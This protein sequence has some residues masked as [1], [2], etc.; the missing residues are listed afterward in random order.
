MNITLIWLVIFSW[1]VGAFSGL[2]RLLIS[3][4]PTTSRTVIGFMT[5]GGMVASAGVG[6]LTLWTFNIL[7]CYS[8][9]VVL[10]FVGEQVILLT[11]DILYKI[12]TSYARGP[13]K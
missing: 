8:T 12:G 13:I 1:L 9:A 2:V 5:C 6:F 10:G 11:L 3:S 4:K 7:I